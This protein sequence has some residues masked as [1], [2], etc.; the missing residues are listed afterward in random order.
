MASVEE[1]II[2]LSADNS[3]LK[4]KLADSEKSVGGL[5]KAVGAIGPMIAGAFTAGAVLALGQQMIAITAKF[6]TYNAV[7]KNTLGSQSKRQSR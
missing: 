6:Q 2:K 7:L 5:G 1:L 4:K 3:D